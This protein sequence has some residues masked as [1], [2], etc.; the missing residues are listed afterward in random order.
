MN[1]SLWFFSSS[2]RSAALAPSRPLSVCLSVSS[3]IQLRRTDA[4]GPNQQEEQTVRPWRVVTARG[5]HRIDAALPA[6]GE[7]SQSAGRKEDEEE[8]KSR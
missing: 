5:H 8:A 6:A 3:A 1:V 4:D 7:G 2:I